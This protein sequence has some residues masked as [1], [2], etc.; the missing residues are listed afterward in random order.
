MH[1]KARFLM[2]DGWLVDAV[3]L[4]SVLPLRESDMIPAAD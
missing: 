1:T 2:P 3:A 4:L